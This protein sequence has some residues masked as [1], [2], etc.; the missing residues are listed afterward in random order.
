MSIRNSSGLNTNALN[1]V[2]ACDRTS[3]RV[4]SNPYHIVDY[5]DGSRIIIKANDNEIIGSDLGVDIYNLIKYI[6]SNQNTCLNQK[7]IVKV[8][9]V[10]E[11]GDVIADGSATDLG[12]L[13]V[14][15]NVLVAFMPWKD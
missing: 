4:E 14:G 6:R 15:Q 3:I 7:P 2:T 13:A 11:V 8:G 1:E 5:V 12:E 10:V 9:D